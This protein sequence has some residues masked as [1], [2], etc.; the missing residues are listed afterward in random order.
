MPQQP[1]VL[2][3]CNLVLGHNGG[4][5]VALG[6]VPHP[7]GAA[8]VTVGAA[9]RSARLAVVGGRAVAAVSLTRATNAIVHV[10]TANVGSGSRGVG[11]GRDAAHVA[12][13]GPAGAAA[14][15]AGAACVG[16][17]LASTGGQAVAARA[18]LRAGGA[19]A[20]PLVAGAGDGRWE[21]SGSGIAHAIRPCPVRA[22]AVAAQAAGSITLLALVGGE[23]V[24]AGCL[25]RASR[26]A[27]APLVAQTGD[28]GR[29]HSWWGS[30]LVVG[31]RPV[32]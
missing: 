2:Q 7:V 14:V 5:G 8:A 6:V 24:T 3:Q 26:A 13:P 4:R 27:A 11:G 25:G 32:G 21:W 18:L 10:V 30:A 20:A 15:T 9:G 29:S 23:A 22:A 16:T 31:P 12:R 17:L 28:G 1:I 19:A